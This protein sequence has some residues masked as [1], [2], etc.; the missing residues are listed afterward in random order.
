LGKRNGQG[1]ITVIAE[2]KPEASLFPEEKS[3][4]PP[5]VESVL[6]YL[7]QTLS[8]AKTLKKFPAL[9]PKDLQEILE[10][11]LQLLSKGKVELSSALPPKRKKE[12]SIHTDGASRGNPGEAGIGI[13]IADEHGKTVKELKAYLGMATNN[14]AEYRAVLVALEKAFELGAE[15]V[16]ISM[17]SELVVRQITGEYKVREAHLKTLHRQALD[18][19]HK[20]RK[21]RL[22]HIPRE[23]NRRADQL[24]N[25]AIDQKIRI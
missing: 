7:A 8:V 23:Q 21:Y 13:V 12:F 2:K 4:S 6:S 17:D 19:L 15:S 10:R 14:V 11:C 9:K 3:A 22:Q 18:L 16:I 5:A 1:E 24:A 20:F 25:E